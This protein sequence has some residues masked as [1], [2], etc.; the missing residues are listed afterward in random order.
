MGVFG[1]LWDIGEAAGPMLAGFL[2]GGLGY[3]RTFDVLAGIT[4]TVT[5][6]VILLVRDPKKPAPRR[7]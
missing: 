1:T 2:I 6:V 5:V 4:A 7:A 3:A